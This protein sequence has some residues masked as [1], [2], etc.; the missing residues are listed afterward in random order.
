MEEEL[1]GYA[2]ALFQAAEETLL[3]ADYKEKERRGRIVSYAKWRPAGGPAVKRMVQYQPTDALQCPGDDPNWAQ[4]FWLQ[5]GKAPHDATLCSLL[6]AAV[7]YL[8][9]ITWDVKSPEST[10]LKGEPAATRGAAPIAPRRRAMGAQF[11]YSQVRDGR[12]LFDDTVKL[13]GMLNDKLRHHQREP[14]RGGYGE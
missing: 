14:D 6:R 7:G 10:W 4:S 9:W 11:V 5:T 3:P 8:D 2:G 1:I 12:N 13:I